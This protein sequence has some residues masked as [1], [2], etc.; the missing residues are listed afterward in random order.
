MVVSFAL[1]FGAA[2]FVY[3]LWCFYD[4]VDPEKHE[5]LRM[6]LIFFIVTFMLFIPLLM[7]DVA[8]IGIMYNLYLLFYKLFWAYVFSFFVLGILRVTGLMLPKEKKN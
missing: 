5:L 7:L 3:L 2:S 6:I 8:V 1:I 4:R